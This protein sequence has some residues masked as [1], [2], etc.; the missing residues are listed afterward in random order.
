MSLEELKLEDNEM[1]MVLK[2]NKGPKLVTRVPM[3][4][5]CQK[6][7]YFNAAAADI[8]PDRIKWFV[9]PEYVIGLPTTKDDENGYSV[10]HT[11]NATMTFFPSYLRN[12][13]KLKDGHYKLM[14]FENGFAFKRYEQNDDRVYQ[15]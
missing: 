13:K 1:E 10:N 9:T 4:N 8:I 7:I 6:I 12:V 14:K 15:A 11:E 5:L 2:R 3:A